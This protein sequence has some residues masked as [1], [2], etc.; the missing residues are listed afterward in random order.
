MESVNGGSKHFVARVD[1][2]DDSGVD[3]HFQV[4]FLKKSFGKFLFPTIP[5]V[6]WI[7][8][9]EIIKILNAPEINKRSQY[10]FPQVNESNI[11]VF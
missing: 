3:T 5:D 9:K 4:S 2:I 1:V 7:E 8:S 11:K 10:F 6:S